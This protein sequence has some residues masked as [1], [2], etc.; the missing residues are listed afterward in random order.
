M[1]SYRRFL[2]MSSNASLN[3]IYI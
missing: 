1:E 3:I 2:K